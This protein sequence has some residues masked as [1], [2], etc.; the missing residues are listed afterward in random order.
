M[1]EAAAHLVAH[2]PLPA[3][4][5]SVGLAVGADSLVEEVWVLGGAG[6]RDRRRDLEG[7]G[8]LY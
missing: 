7:H 6:G 8:V 5:V 3:D 2:P 4:F 1:V